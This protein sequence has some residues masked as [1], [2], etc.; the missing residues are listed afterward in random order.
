MIL[1]DGDI[2]VE[3]L[4]VDDIVE[5]EKEVV[6]ELIVDD[7]IVEEVII[8]EVI[9]GED[10]VEEDDE[11]DEVVEV[12]E[13]IVIIEEEPQIVENNITE[14]IVDNDN[15][16]DNLTDIVLYD[17]AN[18]KEYEEEVKKI[19]ISTNS[20]R[21]LGLVTNIKNLSKNSKK[22]KKPQD[23]KALF[24]PDLDDDDDF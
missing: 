4:V 7:D 11:D 6:E 8:E 15:I 14:I 16:Q 9:E 1:E 19:P 2:V 12:V 23:F 18:D 13:D 5:E 22:E 21:N 24:F 3:E 10:V 20:R 17:S